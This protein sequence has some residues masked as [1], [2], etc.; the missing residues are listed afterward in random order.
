MVDITKRNALKVLGGTAAIASAPSLATGMPLYGDDAQ[1]N[2]AAEADVTVSA[3]TEMSIALNIES[4]PRLTLTNH[5]DQPI[6]LRHIHPGIVHAGEKAFDLNSIFNGKT[7]TIAAGS[8]RS[9]AI[10]PTHAT[11]AETGFPRHLYRK[12][13]QRVVAVR[14]ND[15]HGEFINSSRSFYA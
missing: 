9:F 15:H 6:A 13:P 1:H 3:S 10:Q 2:T 4:V 14:G 5:S 12:Q 7:H 11:Q 8:S